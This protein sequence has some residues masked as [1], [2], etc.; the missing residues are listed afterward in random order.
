MEEGI[1]PSISWKLSKI[2]G[3]LFRETDPF[4]A[5]NNYWIVNISYFSHE[6]EN[7]IISIKMC[8]NPNASEDPKH[9]Y[10]KKEEFHYPVNDEL[11][12]DYKIEDG[13]QYL[14]FPSHSIVGFI[15]SV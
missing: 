10:F 2:N 14:G 11:N 12:V 9:G 4:F 6:D 8:K 3:N 15:G 5:Q 7:M 1:R 13:Q